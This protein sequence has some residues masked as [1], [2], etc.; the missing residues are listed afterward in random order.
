MV[1]DADYQSQ[2]HRVFP[3]AAG[4]YPAEAS[5]TGDPWV[6]YHVVLA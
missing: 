5:G 3:L 6:R 4:S 2:D 1:Y